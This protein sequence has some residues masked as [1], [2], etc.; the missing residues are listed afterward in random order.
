MVPASSLAVRRR[1]AVNKSPKLHAALPLLPNAPVRRSSANAHWFVARLGINALVAHRKGDYKGTS[2][3]VRFMG[4]Q[5]GTPMK[6]LIV[7]VLT[8]L[9]AAHAFAHSGGTDSNGCHHNRKT[10]D[11]HCH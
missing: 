9:L 1:N 10:G 4:E 6:K 11:Y 5:K 8:T 3:P 7:V 2:E